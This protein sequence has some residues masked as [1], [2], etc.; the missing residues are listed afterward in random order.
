MTEGTAGR[1]SAD[2]IAVVQAHMAS[3]RLPGK[4]LADLG[5]RRAID[6]VLDRLDRCRE[7]QGVVV[8]TSADGSDD[9]LVVALAARVPV[10]RGP[11]EDVLGRFALVLAEHPC[12]ALVRI[13]GDCPLID[14]EVVDLVVRR[15]RDGDAVYAANVIEPRTYPKGMATEVISASPLLSAAAEATDPDDRKHVTRFIRS[16][17]DRFPQ[18]RV[19]LDPPC[20]NLRLVLTTPG[21]LQA[22]RELIGRVGPDAG[23]ERLMAAA[24][25]PE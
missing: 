14:P 13:T 7:L 24:E 11:A 19:A 8:A 16:R 17:P 21:D 23:L 10:V 12:D 15:W 25:L 3:N 6:M 2:V 20:P 22:L 1:A 5:G 9:A 18:V 4:A